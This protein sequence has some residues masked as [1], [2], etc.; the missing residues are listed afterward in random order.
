MRIHDTYTKHDRAT[1]AEGPVAGEKVGHGAKDAARASHTTGNTAS[2]S[3]TFSP[4]ARELASLA[5]PSAARVSALRE[6]LQ[7]GELR[8]D[9]H[10]IASKLIGDDA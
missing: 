1:R 3:V 10:A 8:V 9:A 4:R 6:Q 5:D 7:R 2:T